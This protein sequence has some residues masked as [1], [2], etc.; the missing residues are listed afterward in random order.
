MEQENATKALLRRIFPD[1]DVQEQLYDEW[2]NTFVEK[3]R[4][5]IV[6]M[7]QDKNTEDNASELEEQNK[8]L[9]AL[10]SHYKR[11]IEETV[12][13][14]FIIFFSI[15]LLESSCSNEI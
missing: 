12:N 6:S 4:A 14:N 15:I 1:I 8:N 9:Q 10:V 5:V 11:I 7:K 2:I 3:A 13:K